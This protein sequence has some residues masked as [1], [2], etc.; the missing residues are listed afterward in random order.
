MSIQHFPGDFRLG[1][2]N[3]PR[4]GVIETGPS[5]VEP[6][7][8]VFLLLS[9]HQR[10]VLGGRRIEMDART[11]PDGALFRVTQPTEVVFE[12]NF[13]QPLTKL[14]LAM[15]PDWLENLAAPLAGALSDLAQ[16]LAV[17]R[18]LPGPAPLET[19]RAILREEVPL[20]RM[21]LGMTLLDQVIAGLAGRQPEPLAQ[22]GPEGG[23]AILARLRREIAATAGEKLAAPDLAR[24][25]GIGLRSLE[26]L[27]REAEG[28]SLG[29]LIRTERM[30]MALRS[31]RGGASVAQ[32]AHLAGYG[33]AGN[34]AT[35]LRNRF[36][37]TPTD[38][39]DAAL[40]RR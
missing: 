22:I 34:F 15:P 40:S 26:R 12:H 1:V 30:E 9:G 39:R 13:G 5:R 24:R 27:V 2:L 31:L 11:L 23:A 32:A 37:M 36:G 17:L 20:R 6:K 35:A 25:C 38:A 28:S 29:A 21:A 4:L 19:A 33:S 3:E 10:F 18:F 8:M 7:L 14:S 16:D